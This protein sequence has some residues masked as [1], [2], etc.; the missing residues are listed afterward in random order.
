[1]NGTFKLF[2][3][4]DL[5]SMFHCSKIPAETALYIGME[6]LNWSWGIN[7]GPIESLTTINWNYGTTI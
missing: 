6:L 5:T 3:S 7:Y 4:N 2:P 1:M